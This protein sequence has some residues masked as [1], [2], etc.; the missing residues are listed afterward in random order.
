MALIQF[1]LVQGAAAGIIQPLAQSML[2]DIYPKQQHGRMLAIWGA[3]IMTGPILGPVLGGVITD[4]A[5]WR[6]IFAVNAPL[7]LIAI[8]GLGRISS[9]AE[10]TG[11]IGIDV[12]GILLLAVAVGSLQLLLERSIGRGWPPDMEAATEAATAML[13]LSALAVRSARVRFTVL[14]LEVFRNIN[15]TVSVFY[16]FIVG[17]LLFTTIVFLPALSEGPLG[18][19]AT[20]AGLTIS[21]RGIGTMATMLAVGYLINRVDHRALLA[22][23]LAITGG[24]FELMS[25]VPPNADNS[26]WSQRARCRGSASACCSLHSAP[27]PFRASPPSCALMRRVSTA[28]CGSSAAPPA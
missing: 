15:F 4:I 5:S 18:Y 21:P 12:V 17:A 1:R 11:A 28:C 10:T 6:W 8:L 22:A 23:G 7:G 24:A 20:R 19:G 2:L 3:T 13:S 26:G 9:R 27:W 25:R 16:N 14:R